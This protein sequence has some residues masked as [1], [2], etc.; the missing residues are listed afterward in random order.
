MAEPSVSC[1][2]CKQGLT[3]PNEDELVK[4]FKEH[5]KHEHGMEMSEEEA[6]EKMKMGME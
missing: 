2:I 3:A 1:P 4:I 5:V 6:K